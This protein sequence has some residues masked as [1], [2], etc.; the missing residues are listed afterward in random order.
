MAYNP[1]GKASSGGGGQCGP[2]NWLKRKVEGVRSRNPELFSFVAGCAAGVVLIAGTAIMKHSCAESNSGG[3]G[4]RKK[5]VK[6]VKVAV[7]EGETLG[8]ILV[9]YVGD[10][11]EENLNMI[12]KLNKD[13][14]DMDFIQPGQEVT[15]V[16]LRGLEEEE[17]KKEKEKAATKSSSAKQV[18]KQKQNKKGS[19]SSSSTKKKAKKDSKKADQKVEAVVGNKDTKKDRSEKKSFWGR[20]KKVVEEKKENNKKQQQEKTKADKKGGK[21]SKRKL[22]QDK[23]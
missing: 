15:V 20:K 14:K 6:K 16:D 11:T 13:I 17:K 5:K 10:Y 18:E 21:A 7:Q 3:F 22:P 8:D 12:K 23:W 19:S 1:E 9:K 2:L 4:T